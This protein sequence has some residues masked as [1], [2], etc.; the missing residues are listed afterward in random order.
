MLQ[1]ILARDPAARHKLE[2]MLTYPGVHA[3]VLHRVSHAMWRVGLKL[4]A[5]MVSWLARL[6]TGIEIH[7][8]AAIGKRLFIDH[9]FGVV[10]GETAEIGDDVTLY[11]G[12]TLGGT[13]LLQQKRH[14]SLL[15]GVIVGA[16]AQILGPITVGK[17][18]RVGA[19]AVVVHDVP[20]G[21]TVVGIPA[22]EVTLHNT[23]E[24]FTSYGTPRDEAGDPAQTELDALKARMEQLEHKLG[25]V[26]DAEASASASAWDVKKAL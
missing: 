22:R 17:G 8:A 20:A 25:V 19:N 23:P 15:D 13:S 5:R 12:V 6:L 26:S 10:I 11:H 21:A 16:G 14:P 2:V 24:T 18:A 1:S 9:G 7:P 4:P 3:I